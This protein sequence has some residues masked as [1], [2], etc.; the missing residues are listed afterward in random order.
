MDSKPIKKERLLGHYERTWAEVIGL[1]NQIVYNPNFGLKA[2]W[3]STGGFG[4][5]DEQFSSSAEK[6]ESPHHSNG[7]NAPWPTNSVICGTLFDVVIYDMLVVICDVICWLLYVMQYAS[8]YVIL[9]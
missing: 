7:S 6:C 8:C 2:L 5:L 1:Y 3:F 4:M 9:A